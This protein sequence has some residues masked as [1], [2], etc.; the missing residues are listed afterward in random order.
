MAL[1]RH[2]IVVTYQE[3]ALLIELSSDDEPV[4]SLIVLDG[5]E[6]RMLK[7]F[8]AVAESIVAVRVCAYVP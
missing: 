1:N 7:R 8:V 3:S 5:S 4:T 6:T 2:P